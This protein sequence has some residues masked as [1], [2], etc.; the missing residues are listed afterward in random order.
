[1][2]NT[3]A[4]YLSTGDLSKTQVNALIDQMYECAS[5]HNE[6][7]LGYGCL[8]STD[9]NIALEILR[10]ESISDEKIN[11]DSILFQDLNSI[12]TEEKQIWIMH[13]LS[14]KF[15]FSFNGEI[16]KVCPF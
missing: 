3:I 8:Y 6:Y 4:Y 5:V 15:E 10:H 13:A 2:K 1:M 11:P 7:E 12:K 9:V 14:T 16:H